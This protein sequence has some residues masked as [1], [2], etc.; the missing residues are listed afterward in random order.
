MGE[1]NTWHHKADKL[2]RRSLGEPIFF[3][4]PQT[5]KIL[6]NSAAAGAAV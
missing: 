5:I 3:C 2:G 4:S 1:L 6:L